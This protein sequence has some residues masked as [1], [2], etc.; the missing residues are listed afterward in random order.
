MV[1]CHDLFDSQVR[2][3]GP[4]PPI[5]QLDSAPNHCLLKTIYFLSTLLI[6]LAVSQLG[7]RTLQ[8]SR[9]DT[10]W[11]SFQHHLLVKEL[12]HQV[13]VSYSLD[14]ESYFL[15]AF[16]QM[17]YTCPGAGCPGAGC[18]ESRPW[19]SIRHRVTVPAAAPTH[20]RA[21]QQYPGVRPC[22]R[23]RDGKQTQPPALVKSIF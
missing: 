9:R 18:P 2:P 22:R 15:F 14:S 6:F 5:I 19:G 4:P 13:A 20:R 10:K 21:S 8:K 7:E 12:G 11:A 1:S 23:H 3:A 17:N 16:H